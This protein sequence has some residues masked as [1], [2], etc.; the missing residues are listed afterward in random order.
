MREREREKSKLQRTDGYQKGG[1]WGEG[2][3]GD[4]Y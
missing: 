4:G 2:E 1:V 3:I